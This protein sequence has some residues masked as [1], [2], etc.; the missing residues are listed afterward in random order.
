MKR[1]S[2]HL[3]ELHGKKENDDEPILQLM[4]LWN[5][6]NNLKGF[7]FNSTTKIFKS[8]YVLLK[9]ITTV[10]FVKKKLDMSWIE[11]HGVTNDLLKQPIPVVY[12]EKAIKEANQLVK[13][14]KHRVLKS[15]TFESFLYNSITQTSY[16]LYVMKIMSG[17]S[18]YH[19][20]KNL[21]IDIEMLRRNECIQYWKE[22]GTKADYLEAQEVNYVEDFIEAAENK[23]NLFIS[24]GKSA[25]NLLLGQY[26]KTP[27]TEDMEEE[28]YQIIYD[29][30]TKVARPI[31]ESIA[32]PPLK[33]RSQL[34][35][36]NGYQEVIGYFDFLRYI[37]KNPDPE[38][39][40]AYLKVGGKGTWK[41]FVEY[42]RR[43]NDN[44]ITMKG[45]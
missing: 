18:L 6:Q 12:I 44:Y 21:I 38:F 19:V 43:F 34:H 25:I 32:D 16:L 37:S 27:W 9:Q 42:E 17:L 23:L 24:N 30:Y 13:K 1:K 28:L 4:K 22:N 2:P 31:P 20:L 5:E 39:N 26:E 11:E 7:R 29:I 33:N 40:M 45:K 35:K 36:L 10:G 15:L 3:Q 41:T 14:P 8:I